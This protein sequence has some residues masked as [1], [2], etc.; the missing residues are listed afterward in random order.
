MAQ[1]QQVD[2]AAGRKGPPN[3]GVAMLALMIALVLATLDNMIVGTAMPTIVGDLGGVKHL[4]WV[5]AAY[6]LATAASTPIWGKIG[7]MYGRKGIFLTSIVIFLVGSALCGMAQNMGEL[8]GF[9]TL[10]GLGAGGLVVGVM[11][12]MGDLVTPRERGKYTGIISGVMSAAMIGGPLVGG[13][14]TDHLGWRWAFYVNLPLGVIA[15]VTV[16]T[17]IR[18]PKKR[19]EAR[20][21]YLGATLLAAGITAIVLVTSWGGSE[22]SWGSALIVGLIVVGVASLAGFLVVQTKAAEPVMPLHVFR[23]GNFVM[24]S[25]IGFVGGFVMFGAML[26]M[27]LYQQ[28]VQG[29]S[30]TNSGLLLLP[31]LL[32]MMVAS[33][34][35]GRYTTKTGKYKVFPVV[36]GT[37]LL[38]VGLVLLSQMDAETSRLVSSLDMVALGAGMGCTM[39]TSLLIAQNSV[40]M[41]DIG[42]ASSCTT[43][44]RMLGSSFGVAIM[45]V[46]FSSQVKDEMARRAGSL[47]SSLTQQSAHLDAAS[48]SRLPAVVRHAYQHAVAAGTHSAFL[49]GAVVTVLALLAGLFVKETPLR[50]SAPTRPAEPADGDAAGGGPTVAEAV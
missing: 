13:A 33:P 3:V 12:I 44:F 45:G 4:S 7:D 8:I 36:V 46:L 37:A 1:A 42:V 38:V 34:I 50:G 15:L 16:S 49:V 22:Y 48:L 23:S 10:Q 30:A 28:A 14:I 39:Q 47:G 43:L 5:I 19:A 31:L 24:V 29:A 20:I 11:A 6:T 21:D 9:R 17:V 27:P 32:S 40:E 26:F 18:L 2:D 35:A 25:V 41:K